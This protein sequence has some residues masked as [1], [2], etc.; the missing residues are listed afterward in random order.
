MK[1][2]WEVSMAGTVSTL[3]G[4]IRHKDRNLRY[5]ELE[6]KLLD[7]TGRWLVAVAGR[8]VVKVS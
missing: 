8:L 3:L 5:A 6:M 1:H 4:L 2:V 7:V